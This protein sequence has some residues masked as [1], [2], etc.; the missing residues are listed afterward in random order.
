MSRCR[1]KI[2]VRHDA[3]RRRDPLRCLQSFACRNDDF[4]QTLRRLDYPI[5]RRKNR[6]RWEGGESG[7]QAQPRGIALGYAQYAIS[8]LVHG[9]RITG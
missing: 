3:E 5:S 2:R 4:R 1:G 8:R 7:Q 9:R 6:R